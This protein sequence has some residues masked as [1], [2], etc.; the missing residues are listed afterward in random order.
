MKLIFGLV[1]AIV[2]VCGVIW[3]FSQNNQY[4]GY[5]VI[6]YNVENKNYKLLVADTQ[7]KW[8]KGLMFYTKL[9]NVDGMIFIFPNEENRTFW[10]ENT[11]MDLNI[12]WI[13][14]KKIIGKSVLPSIERTKKVLI[15]SSPGK[16]NTVIELEKLD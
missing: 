6:S 16:V 12:Y 5:K 13:D 4:S 8:E 10:N 15:V 11:L 14:N 9:E 2:L 1:L 7:E 3:K